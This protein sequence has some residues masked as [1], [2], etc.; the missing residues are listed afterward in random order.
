M[1]DGFYETTLSIA[2]DW[3]KQ[4]WVYVYLFSDGTANTK[5]FGAFVRNVAP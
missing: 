4:Q 1:L 5:G 2:A 3:A